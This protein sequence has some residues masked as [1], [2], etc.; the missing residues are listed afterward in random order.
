MIEPA[1]VFNTLRLGPLVEVP[2]LLSLSY[3]ALW[4]RGRLNWEEVSKG[5][6]ANSVD[7]ERK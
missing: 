7:V 6:E 1:H 3:L 2:V 4:L 5:G